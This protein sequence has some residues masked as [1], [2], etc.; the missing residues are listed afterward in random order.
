VKAI[1]E[2]VEILN[3]DSSSRSGRKR[4]HEEDSNQ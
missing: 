1:S 4:K 2:G 3:E